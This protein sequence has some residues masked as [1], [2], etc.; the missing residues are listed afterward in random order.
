MFLKEV[1]GHFQRRVQ[2]Q[3]S[4][5]R[6]F[7]FRLNL[8]QRSDERQLSVFLFTL[9]CHSSQFLQAFTV[10]DHMDEDIQSD[11]VPSN[12]VSRQVR[13]PYVARVAY[14]ND[15]SAEARC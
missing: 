1:T 7:L 11:V 2:S 10:E 15:G 6:T 9:I 4:R 13:P 8:R 5:S 14:A 12:I 3:W